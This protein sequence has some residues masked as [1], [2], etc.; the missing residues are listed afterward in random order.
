V[1]GQVQ[2]DLLDLEDVFG[3]RIVDTR[4]YRGITIREEKRPRHWK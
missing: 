1:A 4:L 3:K 2:D